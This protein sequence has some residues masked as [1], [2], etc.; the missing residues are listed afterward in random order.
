MTASDLAAAGVGDGPFVVGPVQVARMVAGAG[1]L[2][3]DVDSLGPMPAGAPPMSY[4]VAAWVA[5]GTS[6]AA[7]AAH[8]AMGDQDWR[9]APR[10]TFPSGVLAMFVADL[11]H[12][13]RGV[14]GNFVAPARVLAVS[15]GPCSAVTEFLAN[16][17]KTLFEAL[18]LKSKPDGTFLGD[19]LAGIATVWGYAVDIAQ[20]VVNAVYT[21]ITEPVFAAMRLAAG[22]LG[23]ATMI[24]TYLSDQK[25]VVKLAKPGSYPFA[26]G[27]A[28]AVTGQFVATATNLTDSWPP[29]I[30]DCAKAAG[31]P[32]PELNRPGS[33]STWQ[34]VDEPDR[35]GM[36]IPGPL[37]GKV[38]GD[39]TARL[40]FST[41]RETDED[42]KGTPD[43]GLPYVTVQVEQPMVTEFLEF[44]QG[45]LS[46]LLGKTLDLIPD[47]TARNIARAKLKA[48]TDPA[49]QRLRD[50]IENRVGGVY[51]L[52]GSGQV[53]VTFHRPPSPSAT[54]SVTP[55]AAPVDFCGRYR[56]VFVWSK[57]HHVGD[58]ISPSWEVWGAEVA[59][60]FSAILPMAGGST[61]D[62]KVMI[63]VYRLIGEGRNGGVV[64]GTMADQNFL[65]AAGR[66]QARCKTPSLLP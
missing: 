55:S 63:T 27:D 19:L 50:E 12:E 61:A 15:D 45:E 41:N 18:K 44:A 59:N 28:P 39:R 26:V 4:L 11:A 46:N 52:K 14:P 1:I 49:L 47:P 21:V 17:I 43:S 38:L 36:I 64:G 31:R 57:P 35:P 33:K 66:L 54:P 20:G 8:R 24:A 29:A 53:L 10:L 34:V 62:L 48:M 32:L 60:R 51:T 40:D 13:L 56:A 30:K 5:R 7:R 65:G 25:L 2:G 9:L 3:A 23:A 22:A 42:A 6:P 16:A 58:G 37:S